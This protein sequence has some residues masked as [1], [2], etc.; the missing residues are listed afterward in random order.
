MGS[1]RTDHEVSA[2]SF[3]HT[4][5]AGGPLRSMLGAPHLDFEVWVCRMM[6]GWRVAHFYSAL[7]IAHVSSPQ[8]ALLKMTLL[9]LS[10][11]TF[12]DSVDE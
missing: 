4:S 5:R 9:A 10:S 11:L 8:K 1:R 7:D 3:A 6:A 2:V 12:A